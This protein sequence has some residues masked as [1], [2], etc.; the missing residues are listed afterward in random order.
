MHISIEKGTRAD[1]SNMPTEL[2]MATVYY[3][4][5]F[6]AGVGEVAAD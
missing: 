6:N 2:T 1:A 3:V 4:C 5:T